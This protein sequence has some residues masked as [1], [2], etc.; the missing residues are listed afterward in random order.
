MLL[1]KGSY[2][3]RSGELSHFLFPID[4]SYQT[5]REVVMSALH[6]LVLLLVFGTL[7]KPIG[8]LYRLMEWVLTIFL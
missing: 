1:A 7:S 8:M 3:L 4:S 5:M 6:Q 2:A